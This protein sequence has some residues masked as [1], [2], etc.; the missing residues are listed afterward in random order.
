[1]KS[2]PFK[3]LIVD[4]LVSNVLLIQSI[5]ESNN[6]ET[7]YVNNGLD[8]IKL[9]QETDFHCILL[10]IMMPGMDGLEVCRQVKL[11]D[12][13][14]QIPIIFIT[15][16]NDKNTLSK[17][18]A[19]GGVDYITKPFNIDE[20]LA[21][22][23]THLQLFHSQLR[24][25]DELLKRQKIQLKLAESEKKYRSLFENSMVAIGISTLKGLILETNQALCNLIGFSQNDILDKNL[26]SLFS[27]KNISDQ[28]I[29]EL[30]SKGF[31]KD[32][33]VEVKKS[34]GEK[35]I[36]MLTCNLIKISENKVF[37]MAL[38]D[39]TKQK[40]TEKR[41]LKAI[42]ETEGKERKFFAQELHDG[43]GPILST[44]K[45]FLQSISSSSGDAK[46][47]DFINMANSSLEEAISAIKEI[48]NILS[49]H[50]LTNF[51]LVS[52]I[53]SF[54][55]KITKSSKISIN[56]QTNLSQRLDNLIETAFYR[57]ITELLNNTLKHAGAQNIH[58]RLQKTKTMLHLEYLDDGKGFNVSETEM[59]G[60][61]LGLVNLRSR[62][63]TLQ[64]NILIESELGKGVKI[65]STIPV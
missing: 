21:R 4:D 6:I 62:I 56:F 50:V 47:E 44:T 33:E 46:K 60:K 53:N 20:V 16:S 5:L 59:N 29:F 18:F 65:F 40:E 28:I 25:K 12:G 57:V 9:V 3:V 55:E 39:I 15:A 10:D 38:S 8:A 26:F 24:I 35:L 22:V 34:T 19:Y 11:I 37:I 64:G 14:S 42:I 36:C 30:S 13:K 45:L 17:A 23:K 63:K 54:I 61:G 7:E 31:I 51:G 2:K 52:A 48:S 1:M 41:I 27:D 58:I 43:L 49:P 32:L